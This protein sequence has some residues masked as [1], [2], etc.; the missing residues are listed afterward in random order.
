MYLNRL[1]ISLRIY[2]FVFVVFVVI[3]FIFWSAF[4]ILFCVLL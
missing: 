1:Y 3:S 4:Y 2:P